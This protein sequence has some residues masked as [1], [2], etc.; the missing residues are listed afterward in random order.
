MQALTANTIYTGYRELTKHAII[1]NDKGRIDAVIPLDDLP[2]GIK[3]EKISPGLIAPGFI[4]LQ[5]NGAGGFMFSEL[6]TLKCI[7]AIAEAQ[8]KFGVTGFLPTLITGPL[9]NMIRASG[10]VDKA[11]N[12]I[13]GVLGIHYE[14]PFLNSNNA[15]IHEIKYIK[16][17]NNDLA[18]HLIPSKFGKTIVTLAPEVISDKQIEHL[19]SVGIIVAAGHTSAKINELSNAEKA[20]LRGVTHLYNAMSQMTA[21]SP[22]T[23][24]AA[25]AND[26]LWCSIIADGNHVHDA[27]FLT[28]VRAKPP[29]KL[30]L[31]SASMA[32]TGK[33]NMKIFT[34]CGQTLFIKNGR[35]ITSKNKLAG[36]L[37]SL[38]SAVRYCV[39]K[40]GI[41]ISEALRMAST[42]PAKAIGED[43]RRGLIKSGYIADLVVLDESLYPQNIWISGKKICSDKYLK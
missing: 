41:P 13:P 42:Y 21:R 20:G 29:G 3:V 37:S 6:P 36:S 16:E 34:A 9:E 24:G 11:I 40:I 2:K 32:P 19:T 31:I 35:C 39:K 26:N 15:G 8:A 18:S 25:L 43:N 12:N 7:S 38:D 23:V 28:A 5:V 30:I 27:A 22:G 10:A 17:F 1:I 33:S 4:D 14:G